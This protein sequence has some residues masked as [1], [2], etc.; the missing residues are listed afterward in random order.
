[1]ADNCSNFNLKSDGK[2]VHWDGTLSELK[3]IV[4]EELKL[5]GTWKSPGVDVKLFT[6]EFLS[7][8]W[9]G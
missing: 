4:T 2:R 1:M 6:T 8:K 7:L 3:Q 9:Q 5:S